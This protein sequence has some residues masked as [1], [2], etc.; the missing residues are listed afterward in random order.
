MSS[1]GDLLIGAEKVETPAPLYVVVAVHFDGHGAEPGVLLVTT[2]A[3]DAVRTMRAGID[4]D[5][6]IGGEEG[7]IAVYRLDP[8][9]RY[10]RHHWHRTELNRGRIT[11]KETRVA[12]LMKRRGEEPR[13]L[14]SKAL[15]E[16]IGVPLEPGDEDWS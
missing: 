16:Q 7:V 6:E 11:D 5:Y 3:K 13:V 1:E 12:S 14:W 10:F 8:G 2:D 9:V 15:R 4:M